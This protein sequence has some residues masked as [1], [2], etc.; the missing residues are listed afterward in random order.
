MGIYEFDLALPQILNTP[1][2]EFPV[3]ANN[4]PE[5]S[6]P[7]YGISSRYANPVGNLL[8]S[9]DYNEQNRQAGVKLG[10]DYDLSGLINGLSSHTSFGFDALNL[11]R[12]GQANQ[13]EG[14]RL[15]LGDEDVTF[16][17]LQTGISDDTR[18]KLHDYYYIRTSFSQS[19]NYTKTI[20]NHGIESS[21][22]YFLYRKFSENMKDPEPQ[23]L[24]V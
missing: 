11:I 1:P 5:L 20:N 8:G 24:D 6:Q 2:V 19:F 3:Y 22:T 7:W 17:R 15:N 13:Y 9:G 16:T 21:L 18:R 12:I 10:I 14:Y 23:L 4:D